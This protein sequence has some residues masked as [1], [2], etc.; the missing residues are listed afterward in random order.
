MN[1]D[2]LLDGFCKWLNQGIEKIAELYEESKLTN[3]SSE[4]IRL[5]S[6]LGTMRMVKDKIDELKQWFNEGQKDSG[7]MKFIEDKRVRINNGICFDGQNYGGMT[8]VSDMVINNGLYW[9]NLDKACIDL[10]SNE[11]KEMCI[12]KGESYDVLCLNRDDFEFID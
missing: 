5:E 12:D 10:L 2:M 3:D 11:Y 8:G 6:K 9:I 1:N 4:C 7:K